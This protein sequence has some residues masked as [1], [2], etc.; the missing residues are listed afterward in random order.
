MRCKERIKWEESYKQQ[1]EEIKE[2]K[3]VMRTT[4]SGLGR[5]Q[6]SRDSD[7]FIVHFK[8]DRFQ[9]A[10]SRNIRAA[11]E[12]L[13]TREYFLWASTPAHSMIT[14]ATYFLK[15]YRRRLSSCHLGICP[16]SRLRYK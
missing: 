1:Q 4:A 11:R 8:G 13:T 15:S 10:T 9:S 12:R 5:R 3:R 2:L 16:L 7:R 6:K 14:P